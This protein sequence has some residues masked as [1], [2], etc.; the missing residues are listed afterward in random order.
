MMGGFFRGDLFL[1]IFVDEGQARYIWT[2]IMNA[3]CR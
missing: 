3:F 2:M 1:D